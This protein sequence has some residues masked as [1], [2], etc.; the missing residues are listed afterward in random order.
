ML[1][2]SL[3]LELEPKWPITYASMSV[4]SLSLYVMCL[5]IAF[6]YSWKS[7]CGLTCSKTINKLPRRPKICEIISSSDRDSGFI[8]VVVVIVLALFVE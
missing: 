3:W 2:K 7:E 4:S 8:L 1:E 5:V 6:L